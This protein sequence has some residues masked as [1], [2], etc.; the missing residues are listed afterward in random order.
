M[1]SWVEISGER[2]ASNF[3]AVQT[4]AGEGVEVLAVIKANAYGHGA[5]LCAPLLV[6]AGANWLGV[7]DVEEGIAVRH[8][9]GQD[10]T[11]IL[12]M[13]GMEKDDAAELL[14]HNL[15]PVVWAPSH[16]E[17]LEAAAAGANTRCRVHLEIDSGMSRQG[18]LP[19]DDLQN[20]IA[21]LNKSTR[22][23]CEGLMTHLCCSETAGADTTDSQW[24]QF[25]LASD[26]LFVNQLMP[27]FIHICNSSAVDEGAP[28]KWLRERFDDGDTQLMV[29]TGFALYGHCLPIDGDEAH[30][31]LLAP[32][33]ATVL[34]WKTRVIGLRDIAPGTT[35]GYGAT[36]TAAQPMRLA[37]LPIGYADG[38]RR[39]GSSGI[40][41]G[42]VVIHGMH[43]PVVGRVSMNLTT[44]D[45]TNINDVAEGTEVTLLGE[46]ATAEDHAN[47]SGTIPYDILCGIRARFTG[48]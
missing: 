23:L 9:L 29:R 33:L 34:T 40:G 15:T 2:L 4:A 1:K 37:L 42:W 32:E 14:A 21:A 46:G 24:Q 8:V 22:V 6:G 41:D 31:P 12:V 18:A 19:G 44:V 26:M 28:L 45:V 36:F 13:C 10:D 35:V 7:S 11:R 47:W 38:F 30:A 16:I 27:E 5:T 17:A 43:A 3:R 39:A 48:V 25:L 20:I